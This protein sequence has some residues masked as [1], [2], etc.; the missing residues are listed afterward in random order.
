MK[1][2]SVKVDSVGI[3]PTRVP[4]VLRPGTTAAIF[5]D[6]GEALL[7]CRSDHGL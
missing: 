7:E 2:P 4:D 1:N 3:P 6:L 5:N